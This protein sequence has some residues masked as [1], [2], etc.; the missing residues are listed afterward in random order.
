TFL[1]MV[2]RY[3]ASPLSLDAYR[4]LA[5]YSGS[6]EAR[7]RH[8]LG[9]FELTTQYDFVPLPANK[10]NDSPIQQTNATEI[11]KSSDLR[12]LGTLADARKWYQ[13]A[14]E[15]EPRLAGYGPLIV[16]D[17]ALQIC[18]QAT[19]R[20]MGHPEAARQSDPKFLADTTG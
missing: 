18:L 4:W 20:N 9:Q 14:L 2:N 1:L 11:V 17:P 19:K 12:L 15:L 5:R 7:R 8:E 16:R 6:S 13:G 10:K 3:P